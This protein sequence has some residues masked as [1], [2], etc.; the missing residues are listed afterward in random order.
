MI[1]KHK[2]YEKKATPSFF[3]LPFMINLKIM[4]AKNPV[5]V[6]RKTIVNH[7]DFSKSV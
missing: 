1:R 4:N 5:S 3:F 6:S 7:R 2:V